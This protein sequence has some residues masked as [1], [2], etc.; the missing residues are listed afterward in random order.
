[1]FDLAS[2]CG[3]MILGGVGFVL[4]G[5]AEAAES[6]RQPNE[7]RNILSAQT[8]FGSVR[9]ERERKASDES[10][11]NLPNSLFP[12]KGTRLFSFF[13][14]LAPRLAVLLHFAGGTWDIVRTTRQGPSYLC[15]RRDGADLCV[16]NDSTGV[17]T[18]RNPICGIHQ[19]QQ[20][21]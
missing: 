21:D 2:V 5:D 17:L 15:T 6:G 12:P 1:M 8:H 9:R 18:D 4:E 13:F 14:D 3:Q 11:E 19:F 7:L 10:A 16:G 20:S